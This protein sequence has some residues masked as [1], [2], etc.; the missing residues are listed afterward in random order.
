MKNKYVRVLW[1]KPVKRRCCWGNGRCAVFHLTSGG[2]HTTNMRL[3]TW[4]EARSY[5]VLHRPG[6]SFVRTV[7][8]DGEVN[9]IYRIWK[10]AIITQPPWDKTLA[11]ADYRHLWT[12]TAAF[13]TNAP[14]EHSTYNS[15]QLSVSSMSCLLASYMA[16]CLFMKRKAVKC[17]C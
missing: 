13:S 15:V 16:W 17:K 1:N 4:R 5:S 14:K 9:K 7:L 3:C 11:H 12:S 6:V 2:R 8:S 10:M